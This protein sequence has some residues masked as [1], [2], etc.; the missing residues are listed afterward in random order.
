[1]TGLT[2]RVRLLLDSLNSVYYFYFINLGLD[3]YSNIAKKLSNIFEYRSSFEISKCKNT[4]KISEQK[5]FKKL[6]TFFLIDFFL[7]FSHDYHLK[8]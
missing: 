3:K 7:F 5:L 1:M 8:K 6:K 4:L 2:I